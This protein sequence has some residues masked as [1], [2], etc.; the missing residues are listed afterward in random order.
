MSDTRLILD[1]L[2]SNGLPLSRRDLLR[3]AGESGIA[4]AAL[5][6]LAG[7]RPEPASAQTGGAMRINMATDIQQLDPH[8][9]TAWNDYCPW[10]SMFSSLTALDRDF[11]P[12]PDLAQSWTQPDPKTYVFQLRK[13]VL[14]HNG[15]EMKA[16]DVKF[17]LE[18]IQGFGGRSK[19]YTLI[20]D[21]ERA[22]VVDDYR[23][24]V[25]LKQPSAP[26]LANLAF[27]MI[28]APENVE[29][30]GLEPVGTGPFRF[31]ERVPNSHL[32]VRRWDKFYMPGQP[33]VDE[34]RW[35]PVV[36]PA[37]RVANLKTGTADIISEV[38]FEALRDLRATPG[39]SIHE[40][41]ASSAY[42]VILIKHAPPLDNKKLRQAIAQLVDREALNRAVYFGVGTTEQGCNPFPIGHWAHTD[43]ACPKYDPDAAKKLLAEAGHP[44]GIELEWKVIGTRPD[45]DQG[46]RGVQ[47]DVPQGR[48]ERQAHPARV[49]HLDPAGVP[50]QAVPA[51]P[52]HLPPG[53]GPGRPRGERALHRRPEQPRRVQPEGHGRP[54]DLGTRR[55]QRRAA[56]GDLQAHLRDRRRRRAVRQ[57]PAPAVPVGLHQQGGRLLH[58]Q[59]VAAVR[60]APRDDGHEVTVPTLRA[61]VG[62]AVITPPV[63]IAHAG[64][65]VQLHQRAEGVDMDLLATVLV[66]ANG[67]DEAAIVDV[68]F[69]V[70]GRDL[71]DPI[72]RA[73][74]DLCGIPFAHIRLSYTHTHSG[75][76]L[77]PSWM[78]E[79]EELIAP[80][81]AS[82]AGRIAGAAW[83]AKRRLRP[84][85][86]V[87]GSGSAAI[88]VN[89]RLK[90]PGGRVVA[91]RNWDGFADSEVKVVRIDDVDE[92]PIAVIVHYG[93]HPTIMGPAEPPDHA[94]LPGRRAQGRRGRDRR[95]LSLP[96]GR[97]R[98][99]PRARQ[100]RRGS[101]PLPPPRRHPRPRGRPG[102]SR[103]PV[104]APAGAARP[105]S[106][107]R[108]SPRHVRRR[109]RRRARRDPARDDAP[110]MAA[111]CESTR[112]S[113]EVLADARQRAA[114]LAE[115]RGRAGED[116]LCVAVGLARRAGMLADKARQYEGRAEVEA[117]LH[118]IR[119]GDVA[120]VGF[121]GEP[122]AELGAQVKARSP[123]PHT[124]FSGYTNDYLGYLPTTEAYPDG[125][126]EVDTS[127][128]RPGSGE[129]LVEASL[130]LLSDLHA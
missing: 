107:V 7:A 122:F 117:E 82:L 102:R 14:F 29:K 58:Q 71:A 91:G 36:E 115:I 6:L 76:M 56:Q 90:L 33:K 106:R 109:A 96:P 24:R 53:G 37:T 84:A 104:R 17:S 47:G 43:V 86:V 67:S 16:A 25:V 126:Y 64:W 114:H 51:R 127:P 88:V 125:G 74:A 103:P 100:L 92:R 59:P 50:G 105:G 18:R 85:R 11:Q 120:L 70:V 77:G 3:L 123:F 35:V 10:E 130:A 45:T 63:G 83:E 113:P 99:R 78:T 9:V 34:I 41:K 48:R 27:A 2:E 5:G 79:G 32:L 61:G 38:P 128:F 121:P 1:A 124:L 19:W 13:G 101:G 8:L 95:Y 112:P 57:D 72:R 49:R 119:I 39:V 54:S 94:R 26:F 65:G 87:A 108:G 129:R 110:R 111:R 98:Q 42:A 97:G 20:L 118:G 69:C 68:D 15:R 89:R 80:Y 21:M 30:I 66:L 81:V 31:V 52:D 73:V 22:E 75:P 23:V 46:R 60:R 28:V 55:A 40:P 44:N 12:V 116:E 4:L 62:R 93:C